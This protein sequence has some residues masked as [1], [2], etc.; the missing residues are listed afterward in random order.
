[1]FCKK[2]LISEDTE[3][4]SKCQGS[5]DTNAFPISAW[6]S[7]LTNTELFFLENRIESKNYKHLPPGEFESPSPP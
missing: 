2:V 1:M 6:E 7:R 3:T 4:H 5:T